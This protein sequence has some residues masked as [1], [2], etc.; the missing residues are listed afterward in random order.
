MQGTVYTLLKGEDLVAT[1]DEARFQMTHQVSCWGGLETGEYLVFLCTK[2]DP[3]GD[4][5][6]CLPLL[7]LWGSDDKVKLIRGTWTYTLIDPDE[8]ELAEAIEEYYKTL[9]D[10]MEE[11]INYWFPGA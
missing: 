9:P 1:M 3:D 10:D 5:G 11:Y 7:M 8:N 4:T 6:K 2:T